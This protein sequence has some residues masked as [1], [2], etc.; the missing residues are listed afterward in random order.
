LLKNVTELDNATRDIF[1]SYD[2]PGN[3]RE[4]QHAIEYAMNIIPREK[5]IITPAYIP[6]HILFKKDDDDGTE[7]VPKEAP[8]M[9][10]VMQEAGRRFLY[11]ALM[12]N[13]GN[14]TKTARS[15]GLTRQNLQYHLKKLGFHKDN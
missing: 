13:Y 1:N 15:L 14:I 11:N 5:N 9:E 3:V 7:S 6:E 4:L 12:E 2:W 10:N 8:T